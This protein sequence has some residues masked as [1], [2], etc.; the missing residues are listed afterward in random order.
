MTTFS[1]RKLSLEM[2]LTRALLALT[3]LATALFVHDLWQRLGH[4]GAAPR[5]WLEAMVFIAIVGFL[6][7]GNVAYQITRLGHLTRLRDHAPM[8]RDT[9]ER[10]YDG[11]IQPLVFLVPSYKEE[12]RIIR[13]TLLSAAL[14]A[15]PNR[16]V[17]LLIDDPD[18]PDDAE[19]LASLM[20]A[21]HLVIDLD[22]LL[23]EAAAP[24]AS[25]R[26]A[27]LQRLSRGTMKPDEEAA[28]LATLWDRAAEWLEHRASQM[29]VTDHTDAFFVET[30]LRAPARAHRARMQEWRQKSGQALTE[31]GIRR[32]Y[33]KLAALFHT[34][35]TSFER[36]R[37][38]NLSHESNKAMNLNTYI[39]LLGGAYK[40]VHRGQSVHLVAD[41]PEQSTLAIA[42]A[43]YLI[44]LDADSLLL[45]D[46]ALR[47]VHLMETPGNERIAVAQTPYSAV[48][49]AT[50]M[51]ERI[52][53]ATTDIQ[54]LVHQGFTHHGATFW[55]GANALL[56]RSALE[57]IATVDNEDGRQVTRYIQDRTVI[58]D[59][60]STVDLIDKGWTLHNYP[61]R[62]A[63]SAT[64]PDFGSLV[65]QRARWANGGL[66][67][68]PKL[69]RY[70]LT[71]P[72]RLRKLHEG[73]FRLHYLTSIAGVN[74]GL[75]A[76]LAY[77]FPEALQSVWLPLT[78]APYYLLYTRDL[79]LT[80]YGRAADIVRVYALNLLLLPVNLGGVLRSLHQAWKGHRIAFRRTPKIA[81][82]TRAPAR[83]VVALLA[84]TAFCL[85]TAVDDMLSRHWGRSVFALLNGV[86]FMYAIH[87]FVGFRESL[88]DLRAGFIAPM[89]DGGMP[90]TSDERA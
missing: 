49:N 33:L 10:I 64:P 58:E 50:G 55:V 69:L 67:I 31:E 38:A 16:R 53:G 34:E 13:Q 70:L 14:Q 36:K 89:G 23:R 80:G 4:Q 27:F 25:A 71:G 75:M 90:K 30:I 12:A 87:V 7:Y 61:E 11:H 20:A 77:P 76:L 82:R 40:E 51:L 68:L 63:Y 24:F 5:Q 29:T 19:G 2:A 86:L 41:S 18:R 83:Y 65:I 45:P 1:Q 88:E 66:I 48:P 72:D 3:L 9:L 39:S 6:I 59:T 47:L 62:L 35:F 57:E 79:W 43:T 56:R 17:V 73:F 26:D 54:Y 74:F 46:Y 37:Y 28:H 81:G 22:K 21:R 44:T 52:A 32:E 78:A 42:Q 85:V 8:D 60:E 15:Y 84:I